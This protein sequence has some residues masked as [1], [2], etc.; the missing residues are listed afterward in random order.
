MSSQQ[1]RCAGKS[2]TTR[3]MNGW[4]LV[5]QDLRCEQKDKHSDVRSQF[6]FVGGAGI[7]VDEA[8]GIADIH[9]GYGVIHYLDQ[10]GCGKVLVAME[11]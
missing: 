10:E 7:Q 1:A 2:L 9:A 6:R 5:A 4:A 11:K 8:C 3:P